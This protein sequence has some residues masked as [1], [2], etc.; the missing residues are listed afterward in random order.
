MKFLMEEQIA[1]DRH[2]QT[3]SSIQFDETTGQI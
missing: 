2:G 1:D 3:N